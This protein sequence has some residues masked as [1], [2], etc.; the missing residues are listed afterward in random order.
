[1]K[2]LKMKKAVIL[3]G[4]EIAMLLFAAVCGYAM[5]RNRSEIPV[6][7]AS[8]SSN[9]AYELV[10]GTW[11]VAGDRLNGEGL[12]NGADEKNANHYH[13][14]SEKMTLPKGDYTLIIQYDVSATQEVSF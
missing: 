8:M 12:L 14:L 5:N 1:M 9:G 11:K 7:Y 2:I 6:D 10:D 13:L 4:G 3:L